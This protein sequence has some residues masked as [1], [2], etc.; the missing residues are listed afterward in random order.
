MKLDKGTYL[1][2]DKFSIKNG[3]FSV[4]V[5]SYTE[6][7]HIHEWHSHNHSHLSLLIRGSYTEEI[8]SEKI[9][10]Q[11]GDMK[12]IPQGIHH[13]CYQYGSDTKCINIETDY[14]T[15]EYFTTGFDMPR[16][17]KTLLELKFLM[18]RIYAAYLQEEQHTDT[19]LEMLTLQL[20]SMLD[21]SII[22]ESHPQWVKKLKEL[23][24]DEYDSQSLSLSYLASQTGVHPVT[25]SKYF[26]KYF[27][28]TLGEYINRIKVEKAVSYLQ[29]TT[30]PLT[31]IAYDCGFADQAH[32]TRSCKKTTGLLPKSFRKMS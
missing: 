18:Y 21:G 28:I 10:R 5:T 29:R 24:Y 4:C 2:S 3:D 8:G 13:T 20:K 31:E 11:P 9:Y 22:E 1:A 30:K 26:P 23:L 7:S 16:Y 14:F 15:R 27:S 32:F 25:I 6:E 19:S 12:Y 17:K